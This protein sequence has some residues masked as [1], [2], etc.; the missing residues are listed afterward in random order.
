MPQRRP[1]L[2]DCLLDPPGEAIGRCMYVTSVV[3]SGAKEC[4]PRRGN[5]RDMR[6]RSETEG[7]GLIDR[8]AAG[9]FSGKQLEARARRALDA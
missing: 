7:L 1:I 2:W 5:G 3:A 8:R 4:Q 6:C 9:C